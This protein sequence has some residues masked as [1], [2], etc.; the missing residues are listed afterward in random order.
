MNKM[1]APLAYFVRGYKGSF[2]KFGFDPQEDQIMAGMQVDDP[3]F[4]VEP[5][6]NWGRAAHDR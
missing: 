6:E 5:K 4:G 3:Q 2:I 1:R